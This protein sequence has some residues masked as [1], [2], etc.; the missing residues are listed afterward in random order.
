VGVLSGIS[1]PS[2]LKNLGVQDLE[3]LAKEIRGMIL[4]EVSKVGGHLASSL[5]AV[6]LTI[7][8]HYVFDAPYDK[9]LWDVG[10]QSYSHKILTGRKDQFSTLR[11]MGGMHPFISPKESSYDP[12]ISGH[13]GNAV[14]AASGIC[15]A[16]SKAGSKNKVIA[17]IGDGSL[18]NGLTL[19]AL[20]F[21]GQKK[22][23]LIVVLNDNKM[24]I[25]KTVGGITDYLS[26][27]MTSKGIRGIKE[28]IKP[29]IRGVPFFGEKI[30]RI[31]KLIEGVLKG[32]VAPSLPFEEMGFRYIGPIDGHNMANLVEAFQNISQ[33]NGPI[34]LHIITKK[35]YGYTPALKD[36][37]GF[38]GIGKFL[39]ENGEDINKDKPLTY[40]DVF[41]NALCRLAEKDS[42][43]VAV[44]AAMCAG[45]GIKPFSRKFPERFFDVGIAEGHAVTF[46]AGMAMNGLRPV[47]AIYSTFL[48]RSYDE[49]IH[50]VALQNAPVVF[51]IDRAGIV[52]P[53]G[54]THHGMFDIA[55]LRSIPN[56]TIMVPRDQIVFSYMIER[57][58]KMNGPVAIRYPR[59]SLVSKP[60]KFTG[61]KKGGAEVIKKGSSAVIFCIGPICYAALDAVKGMDVAVVD[62]VYAK[63]LDISTI[64]TMVEEC[65]GKF[66]VVEEGV[67]Q[68]GVGSAILEILGDMSMPLKFKL[69]GI[70][71][72]FVEHGSTDQLKKD[73]GLD[74]DG[75]KKALEKII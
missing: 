41:G 66:L 50:D 25:S 31:V 61:L 12:F 8:L 47:V 56:I 15:E 46:A 40:S 35:G 36:P 68:G 53:D 65:K 16:L 44:T 10:H 58:L 22:Q 30:F 13:A 73:I 69:L 20:N 18:S 17:V 2:D 64:R 63:P 21:V 74:A 49:I 71:D 14:S 23:N 6:D 67:V 26:R 45:T 5:G 48:Q 4:K 54:A 59:G 3:T 9:I 51:A 38:H 57:S 28:G 75:I 55:F 1:F 29:A 37:E 62:L 27:V 60:V 39:L 72:K 34:L 52:G 70:P 32:M 42:R 33:I 7:A 43:I 19:E 24:S 11:Q